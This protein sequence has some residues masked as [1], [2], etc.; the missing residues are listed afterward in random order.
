MEIVMLEVNIKKANQLGESSYLDSVRLYLYN[1]FPES[2]EE[3]VEYLNE[4]I[5]MLTQRAKA[6]YGLVLETDI[7]P[8]IVGAWLMGLNFDEQFLTVK[9]ILTNHNLASF[10]KSEQL[11][12]F[13]EESFNILENSNHKRKII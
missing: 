5:S 6:H 9:A 3:P 8:F 2:K 13:L 1:V 10:E 7:A 12:E 4:A 11:W